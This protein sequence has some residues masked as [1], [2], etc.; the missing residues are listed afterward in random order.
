VES[1]AIHGNAMPK[2]IISASGMATGGRV[3]GHLKMMAPDPR[4]TILLAGFQ[5][6]DTRGE[7]LLKGVAELK[8]HGQNVPVRAKVAS[9]TNTSA[10]ADY[11]EIFTWLRGFVKPPRHVFITHGEPEAAASLKHK[12]ET[13]FGWSCSVPEYGETVYL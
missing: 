3:L 6:A 11:E 2:V 1:Q 13:E 8:I 5:A 4:N 9:L 12:I 10:H 7:K